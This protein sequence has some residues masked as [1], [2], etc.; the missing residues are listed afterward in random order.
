MITP[1]S[2]ARVLYVDDEESL[3][4]LASRTLERVGHEVQGFNDPQEA[5][6][7]FKQTP[8][9]YDLV[10]SDVSMPGMNGFDLAKAVLEIRPDLPVVITSGYLRA[11][12]YELAERIGIRKLIL[13]PDTIEALSA[14]L[15]GLLA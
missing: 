13:K 5:L 6:E 7:A 10:V 4:F 12:D 1:K 2:K 14:A 9:W 8:Q 15:T 3:V 11:E